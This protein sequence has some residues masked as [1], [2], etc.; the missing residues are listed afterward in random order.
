MV[1]E[2]KTYDCEKCGKVFSNK[3]N[4]EKHINNPKIKCEED[5]KTC[6]ICGEIFPTKYNR[7]RHMQNK[8]KCQPKEELEE[9]EEVDEEAEEEEL[10]E[11]EIEEGEYEEDI[12][13]KKKYEEIIKKLKESEKKNN[14][15]IKEAEEKIKTLEEIISKNKGSLFEIY[16]RG[17]RDVIFE[18]KIDPKDLIK[19]IEII[20]HEKTKKKIIQ[21][22]INKL[23][24]KENIIYNIIEKVFSPRGWIEMIDEREILEKYIKFYLKIKTIFNEEQNDILTSRMEIAK[25]SYE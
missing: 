20:I 24:N 6:Y 2:K 22:Y 7:D 11:T 1:K 17:V 18:D 25:E 14:E 23:K 21:E 3:T 10:E 16:E 9:L 5:K 8:K 13:L 4:L 15:I 12:E 19:D